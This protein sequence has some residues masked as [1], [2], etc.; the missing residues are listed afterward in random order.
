MLSCHRRWN[1][2]DRLFHAAQALLDGL[3]VHLL[4]NDEPDLS[5]T[6]IGELR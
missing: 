4:A 3:A 2:L 1:G 5:V 6:P